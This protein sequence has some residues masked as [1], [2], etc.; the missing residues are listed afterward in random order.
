MS[1]VKSSGSRTEARIKNRD[2]KNIPVG[3]VHVTVTYN[4]TF[5]TITD[6]Q[7]NVIVWSVAGMHGFKGSRKSTPYAAQVTAE[8]AARRAVENGVKTVSIIVKG[9]GNGRESAIRAIA[10]SGLIVTFIRDVTP[11]AHNGCRPR[12][13]RCV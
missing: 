12:K 13:R 2:R 9:P 1:K 10:A 7:G 6:T 3:V 4:N 5:I 11:I 8:D